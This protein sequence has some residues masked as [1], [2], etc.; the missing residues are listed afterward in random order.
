VYRDPSVAI[1]P[2][3][4]GLC[5]LHEAPV[6]PPQGFGVF[7]TCVIGRLAVP[8]MSP[9]I[10]MP[11]FWFLS[12]W[13]AWPPSTKNSDNTSAAPIESRAEFL[14]MMHLLLVDRVDPCLPMLISNQRASTFCSR[15]LHGYPL[16]CWIYLAK[17]SRW[18]PLRVPQQ[19]TRNRIEFDYDGIRMDAA[20]LSRFFGLSCLFG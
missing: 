10:R 7:D 8:F 14:Y 19:S 18:M 3:P 4:G 15:L 16:I 2:D 6:L 20:G 17:L 1:A 9:A 13:N 11:A 5:I 12:I